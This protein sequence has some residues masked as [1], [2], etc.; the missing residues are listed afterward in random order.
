MC[1][2]VSTL[3]NKYLQIFFHIFYTTL[4]ITISALLVLHRPHVELKQYAN[5]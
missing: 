2:K 3:Q 5:S 1:S 4:K